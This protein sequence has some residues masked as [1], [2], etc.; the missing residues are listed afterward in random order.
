VDRLKQGDEYV[1][2]WTSEIAGEEE[3]GMAIAKAIAA[4]RKNSDR[5]IW[6]MTYDR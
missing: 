3:V 4:Y 2:E 1:S 6:G 5:T